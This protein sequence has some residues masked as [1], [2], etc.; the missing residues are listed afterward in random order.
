MADAIRIHARDNVAVAL[1]AVTAGERL[2]EVGVVAA[3]DIPQAHKLA[4]APIKPGEAVVKYGCVIGKATADIAPGEWVHTHN[5]RTTLDEAA[6]YEYRPVPH[7]KLEVPAATFDGYVRADGRVAVRNEI[8]IVPT[9]GC[10]NNVAARVAQATQHLAVGEIDAVVPFAHPYGCSQMGDDHENTK[11]VLAAL[12]RHPNAAG[13]LVI[14]LG[15][16]NN[17]IAQFREALGDYDEQR[18]RFLICQESADELADGIRHIEDLARLASAN[19]RQALP[20]SR[21][22][23][24]MKCGGSDGM[25]GVCANPAVGRVADLLTAQGGSVMLTEVP[26]M[27]GAESILFNRCVDAGVFERAVAMIERFKDYYIAHGQPVYENPSPGNKAGG[28]TT[29]EDKSC[30][31]VQKGGHAQI[32][33]VIGYAKPLRKPGLTLLDGPGND[34]VSTTALAAAGAH[35]IL[36]TTGRGTPLGAPA[37]T[38]KIASNSELAARKAGWIDFDAGTVAAGE[39]IES[40]GDRLFQLVLD[41]ASGRRTRQ[42]IAGYREIAIFKTGVTL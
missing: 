15:C 22:V 35:I 25:S 11:E 18:T 14:G 33:D 9:V 17:T 31:C 27:F 38:V 39:S 40:T 26:E 1:R 30:G 10:V 42:E 4:L 29:L 36:F 21:L 6:A 16:E 32:T 13:V 28:I 3:A 8:W 23:L 2:P 19:R 24:G 41:V 34:I 37:P 7:E 12:C 5:V 20:A